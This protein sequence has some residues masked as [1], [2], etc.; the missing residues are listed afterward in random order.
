MTH[1]TIEGV[2]DILS[3]IQTRQSEIITLIRRFVE[4]ESPSDDPA[5]INRFVEMVSDSVAPYASVKRHPGKTHGDHLVCEFA[6]PGRRKSGQVLA[7]GHSD[8]VW[9][10]GTLR[11]MP[12]REA[13]GRLWGPGVLD[14]KSG[15]V[16]FLFAVQA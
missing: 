6:L 11:E 5:A 10:M 4:C 8:T 13:D 7:L 15:I 12:F 16:F 3:H 1:V 2:Q 14:M 9:P